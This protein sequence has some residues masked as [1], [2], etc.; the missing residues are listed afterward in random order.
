MEDNQEAITETNEIVGVEKKVK[1]V[2]WQRIAAFIIDKFIVIGIPAWLSGFLL[3]TLYYRMGAYGALLGL[4][5][6]TLYFGLMNSCL[7]KG[8]TLGK[9][10]MRIKVV[11]SIGE[12]L[13]VSKSLLRA[14]ILGVGVVGFF[15]VGAVKLTVLYSLPVILLALIS[16]VTLTAIV[17]LFL[18]NVKNRQSWHDFAA[19]SFVVKNNDENDLA[20]SKP[21]K[22]AIDFSIL[23]SIAIIV[24]SSFQFVHMKR[25]M[26]PATLLIKEIQSKT[27]IPVTAFS[28]KVTNTGNPTYTMVAVG[29]R[30]ENIRNEELMD[31]TAAM[32]QRQKFNGKKIDY[33]IVTLI[34]NYDIGIT[35][36]YLKNTKEYKFD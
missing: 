31:E 12:Y 30:T 34:R 2:F 5:I 29:L 24:M 25:V 10:L 3:S 36:N 15:S 26:A 19:E 6:F 28:F 1:P 17:T 16:A 27:Y 4:L 21:S 22:I 9:K 23:F 32:L 20:E 35:R 33:A 11:N 7:C 18:F 8:Q 14:F 13:T